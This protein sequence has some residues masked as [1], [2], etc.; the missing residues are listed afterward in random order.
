MTHLAFGLSPGPSRSGL[1]VE[2]GDFNRIRPQQDVSP[3]A[4]SWL[5][6]EDEYFSFAEVTTEER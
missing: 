6:E 3:G 1:K 2:I 5:S 4:G